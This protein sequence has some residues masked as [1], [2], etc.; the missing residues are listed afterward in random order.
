MIVSNQAIKR[1]DGKVKYAL[2]SVE[3]AEFAVDQCNDGLREQVGGTT[4]EM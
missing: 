3:I 2:A 4:Q 1:S